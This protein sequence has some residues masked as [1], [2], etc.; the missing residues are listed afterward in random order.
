MRFSEEDFWRLK[1]YAHAEG[2]YADLDS[3]R[4]YLR[5]IVK[6]RELDDSSAKIADEI[7]DRF[8]DEFGIY[9]ELDR[10]M[11]YM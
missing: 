11:G 4:E 3:F 2:L 9:L 8:F 6:Y 1:L 5:Q 7:Y 10:D